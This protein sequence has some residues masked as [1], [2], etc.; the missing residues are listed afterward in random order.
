MPKNPKPKLTLAER[1]AARL[2]VTRHEAADALTVDVQSVDGYIA[3]K[4]LK[5]S[6]LGTRVLIRVP[7]LIAMLDDHEI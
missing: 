3:S 1:L 6:K 2:T 7:S 4:K 5:A